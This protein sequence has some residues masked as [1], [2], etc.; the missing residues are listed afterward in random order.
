[1][2]F[3]S[4]SS[5][6]LFAL[7]V[8]IIVFYFLKLRRPRQVVPS[9][10]LWRQVLSDQRVNSPFQRFKRNLLLLLQILLLVL[11]ALAA[12]QPFLRREAQRTGR[13][14]ILV[15]VSASMGALDKSGGKTRLEEAK[16]RLLERI[17]ALLPDQEL[18]IVAF[19]KSARKLAGFTNNKAELRDAVAALAVEDVPGQADDALRLTQALNQV[20][21][22]DRVLLLTDGNLPSRA[23]F[24][25][26]FL[27][28]LQK[29][30][31]AGA[32]AGITVCQARRSPGGEWEVFVQLAAT[33]PAPAQTGSLVL[34][35]GDREI[36][37]ES[38][39]FAAG[40]APRL[41]FKV[42]G[43]GGDL[44]A[45]QLEMPAFDSLASDNRAWLSLPPTRPIEVFV[46]E[47]LGGFRHALASME[48]VRVFPAK[49]APSPGSF[50]LA[51]VDES[52]PISAALYCTAGFIPDEIKDL[53]TIEKTPGGAVDW[54]RDSPVLEHVSFDEVIFLESP[55]I[56]EGKDDVDFGNRGYQVLAD[57]VKGPLVV[58]R[59]DERNSGNG[60]VH[61]LFH[62]DRSTLPYRVAFPILVS[63]LIAM[64]QKQAGLSEASA[65]PTGVLPPQQ[66]SPNGDVVAK[67]PGNFRWKEVVDPNGWA[68]GI[69]AAQAGEYVIASGS[70]ESRV[71]ASL[72][73]AAESSL[74]AVEQIEFGDRISVSAAPVVIK[75]DRSLWWIL[76]LAGFAVLLVEW[77]W[78]QRRPI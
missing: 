26:P 70:S 76:A 73:S 64:A 43:V 10:V 18:C 37:R 22:F 23:N 75:S 78:F 77:W 33:D 72:L 7:L 57:G 6:W 20:T 54:R 5:A 48:G 63:N 42:G 41:S 9:L 31:P 65:V 60:R 49:D 56:A 67:G 35:A 14:P 24:D 74:V 39:T 32:N 51:I 38:V 3:S 4:L 19:A 1:M 16:A 50:D 40:G 29:L 59:T 2:S 71:G 8:P 55:K 44:L 36:A 46:P 69:P 28:D 52:A 11:L 25:L 68:T 13:L 53:V 47:K 27:L 62:P 66:G 17:D 15:D 45:V 30:P 21:P 34:R 61:F 12:M 58:S